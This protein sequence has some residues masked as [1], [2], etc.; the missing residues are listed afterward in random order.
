M[1]RSERRP[2]A[3]AP[4][5][6]PNEIGVGMRRRLAMLHATMVAAV[7]AAAPGRALAA[8]GSQSAVADWWTRPTDNSATVLSALI[9][10]FVL[11]LPVLIAWRQLRLSQKTLEAALAQ[12]EGE[13]AVR[14][15]EAKS[16]RAAE[17]Q[18]RLDQFFTTG[19]QAAIAIVHHHDRDVRLS[20]ERGVERVTWAECELALVPAT[21]RPYVYE[22]KLT[23]IR[24]C[25]L[26]WIEGLSRLWYFREQGLLDPIDVEHIV[27]PLL[28]RL[29]A[30][31]TPFF[32]N[33]RIFIQYCAAEPVMVMC[34]E[35]ARD[36]RPSLPDDLERLEAA[37]VRGDYGAWRASPWG[38]EAFQASAARLADR[39]KAVSTPAPH[40]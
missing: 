35:Y 15:A 34:Q 8:A 18:Q 5:L 40:P 14:A 32:R 2:Y 23:A 10:A 7:V 36:I 39:A 33:L 20:A 28:A 26:Q 24:D 6:E 1:G 19:T 30:H 4:D 13:A 16:R 27:K 38:P 25:F 9:S 22:P 12:T 29:V 3:S 37:L 21:Y 11:L 31:D 17:F